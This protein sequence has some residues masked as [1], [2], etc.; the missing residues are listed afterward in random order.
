M[1]QVESERAASIRPSLETVY[2]IS[3]FRSLIDFEI[4]LRPGLNV[5]VG[6]NGSGKTN[7]I[8]FLDFLEASLRLGASTA[9][10]SLGGIARVFSI[11]C[12]KH[13]SPT[14]TVNVSSIAGVVEKDNN[15]DRSKLFNFNY[16]LIIKFS[17]RHSALYIVKESIRLYK[18]RTTDED[19]LSNSLV[20]TVSITRRSPGD[21]APQKRSISKKLLTKDPRNPF[22]MATKYS[23]NLKISDVFERMEDRLSP[24]ESMLSSRLMIPALDAI[25]TALTR[26]RSFNIIP[27]S[28]REPDDLTRRPII[29]RD[30]SGLSATLHHLQMARKKPGARWKNVMRRVSPESLDMIVD[31]TKLVFKTLQDIS[32]VQDPHTGK[33]LVQLVVGDTSSLKIS[34]Q[35]ASDGT[36]KWLAL[37][38]L[39]ISSGAAYSIEEP[40][41]FLHPSMQQFLVQII[42]DFITTPRQEY[43]ILSTHSETIVNKCNPDEIIIFEFMDKTTCHRLKL[44]DRVQEEINKTGFGLGYYYASNA[45]S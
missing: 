3:G 39:I 40:E 24:D 31:W 27:D 35:A 11:E 33:Y 1:I 29:R 41:N 20:G 6:P 12:L 5:L 36:V 43:F 10:S 42:R 2:S 8:E 34:L 22:S 7:F 9:I 19:N 30:G 25:A 38:T 18:L 14:L 17:R 23:S 4:R 28:A 21:E 45:L 32:V 13:S 15:S 16:E 44:P 26:G 37:V